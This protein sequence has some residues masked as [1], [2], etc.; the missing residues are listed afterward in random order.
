MRPGIVKIRVSFFCPEFNVAFKILKWYHINMLLE[1]HC[2]TSR[3]S[4]CSQIAP[5]SLA[6]QVKKK[7]LQGIVIT[8]H[9][10]LWKDDELKALRVEA[11]LDENFLI[12]SGQ[13]VATDIGHVLVF[14]ASRTIE[15]E[16]SLKGLRLDFPGAALVWAHPFRDG[17]MPDEK[18][19]LN[20]MLDAV[21]IFS[22]NQTPKENY[23]GLKAWHKYKF[24]AISGSDTHAEGMAGIYPTQFD[25][26]ILTI[27]DL[28]TGIKKSG[29]RPFFKEIPRSGAN[30]IV[31]EIT[32]G[33]K[34]DDESRNRIILKNITDDKKWE[35]AKSSSALTAFLYKNGFGEGQF[36]VPGII[37]INDSERLIIE[38][39]QRGKNLFDLLTHVD[40]SIGA[41]YFKLA[42]RWLARFHNKAIK[43]GDT[44]NVIKKELRRF[45]S[46]LDSF[47]RTKSPYLKK[48]EPVIEYVKE[49]EEE[50]FLKRG[51]SFILNHG[52]YHPK[53]IIIGQDLQH[54]ITTLFISVIDF[55][56]SVLFPRAFDVG[57][58]I[59]QFQNQFYAHPN[60]LKYCKEADFVDT[61]IKEADNIPIDFADQVKLFKI[62]ASLSI[63]SYLIKV[64]KGQGPEMT[65][66]I[67]STKS[68]L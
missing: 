43:Q 48:I 4:R 15:E 64:G 10:Y 46:Y 34:G 35:A 39:G 26:P 65:A 40:K 41:D 6:R 44:E 17:G 45:D 13:E 5:A 51:D 2:H 60:V 63:A 61:Y 18:K 66:L 14:G 23:L 19:L 1:M 68:I 37:D 28:V 36:R 54:D 67:N 50:M 53:N 20:P 29:C 56:S 3:Y 9:H 30:I 22:M 31:T 58:F 16:I 52:D 8:E 11:E 32:I 62:R 47:K 7:E 59:S 55:G 25:H 49:R 21:E 57:Y 24:T 12:L 33:T 42:A 38:D 27:D